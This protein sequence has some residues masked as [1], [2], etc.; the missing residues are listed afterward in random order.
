MKLK[1][2][3]FLVLLIAL[4]T[5][6]TFAQERA[7]S[8]VVSDNAGLPLPG[9][10]VLVKGTKTGTQTDFDGKYTIKVAPSQTLVFSY[11]GMK[12][13]E[14][15]TKSTSVNVKMASATTELESVVVTAF[16]IKRNP[17]KLG[18]S[19]SSVKAAEITE[20][21]EPD[22]SRAL[23]GKV[24][25]VNV[26]ISTGVAGAA[27]QITIRGVNSLIGNTDPLIIVDGVAYS[28]VSVTSTS[29]ITGGGGYESA[30]SSLDPNDIADISVLKSTAAAALYGSRA[31]NGVIVVT[32]K[33]GASKSSK[34]EKLSVNVG[35]GTYFETI[36]NLPEYQNT[37]GAGANFQYSNANGSWG[38][39]FDKLATIPTWP[40][41]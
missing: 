1:F 15:G 29:Q 13:Q 14:V 35:Q 12:P 36:A 6:I 37:Y 25:G 9:V 10:S 34:A 39:R 40:T 33:S 18:Y 2:N 41:L 11:I 5:Q 22:L 28:N 27:N 30:L 20:T 38:P 21:S 7:V 19:V 32:T 8:G 3:G 23:S 16:G 24:A 31:M 17:K 4:V 26:N